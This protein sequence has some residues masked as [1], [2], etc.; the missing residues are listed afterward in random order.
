MLI[1]IGMALVV[2]S[3]YRANGL[4]RYLNSPSLSHLSNS[5]YIQE[6]VIAQIKQAGYC[7]VGFTGSTMIAMGVGLT[8]FI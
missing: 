8:W 7:V 4:G 5:L 6:M 2:L 1:L 3:V